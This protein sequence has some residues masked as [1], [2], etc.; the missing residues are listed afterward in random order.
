MRP[1]SPCAEIDVS[2][3]PYGDFPLWRGSRRMSGGDHQ[4]TPRPHHPPMAQAVCAESFRYSSTV[5][6]MP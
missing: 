6:M 5:S 1:H 4:A 3:T 2:V